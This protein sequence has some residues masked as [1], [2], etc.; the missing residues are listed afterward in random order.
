MLP[1]ATLTT[2]AGLAIYESLGT[3]DGALKENGEPDDGSSKAVFVFA[4]TVKFRSMLA[5]ELK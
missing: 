1:S 2:V 4:P 3:G 5:A